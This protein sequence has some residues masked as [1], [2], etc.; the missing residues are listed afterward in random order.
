MRQKI[1]LNAFLINDKYA[2]FKN[3]I[4]YDK[5][6]NFYSIKECNKKPFTDE[7]F[8]FKTNYKTICKKSN[9]QCMM[10]ELFNRDVV[11]DCTI[12]HY[13][14]NDIKGISICINKISSK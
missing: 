1:L 6:N 8:Y 11:I 12:T 10:E 4:D 13:E 9:I 2:L 3:K 7:G 14:M 5:V